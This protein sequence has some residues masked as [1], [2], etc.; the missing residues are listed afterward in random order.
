MGDY[1]MIGLMLKGR[2]DEEIDRLGIEAKDGN[3]RNTSEAQP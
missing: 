2:I 3:G 1:R